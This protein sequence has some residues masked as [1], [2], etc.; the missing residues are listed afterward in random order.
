[1]DI[2][3]IIR[4]KDRLRK[5]LS[6]RLFLRFHMFL[7]LSGTFFSGLLATK[8]LL[9]LHVKSMLVRYP[10]AVAA[11]YLAFFGFVKLWLFYLSSSGGNNR[12]V[13]EV[14]DG[15]G[16]ITNVADI[17]SGSFS[18]P[19]GGFSGGGGGHFGG[20]G[21]SGF[22]ESGAESVQTLTS[23]TGDVGDGIADAAGDAASGIFEDAGIV[24][25][26]LGALLALVF[27]AGA[28]LIYE[29]PL[30][31]SEAAFDFLLAASLIRGMKK[32]DNPDWMGSVLRTTIIPFLF[33]FVIATLIAYIAQA[34]CPQAYK[35]SEV[36][37]FLINK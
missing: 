19:S 28:Y 11:A 1:M 12:L 13:Q 16:D 37:R 10:V 35:L 29:A 23:G 2:T 14:A 15:I 21:A 20:G 22:F 18:L 25:V 17:P 5:F 26:V 4:R 32:I 36:I 31:L 30:I 3:A 8:I 27:G 24:L 6:E 7:I 34:A 9:L 33:I